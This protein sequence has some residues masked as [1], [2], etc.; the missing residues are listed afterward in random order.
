MRATPGTRPR[1]ASSSPI[2]SA[3]WDDLAAQ[4]ALPEELY[5]VE[6]G[7]GNGNQAKVFLDQFRHLDEAPAVATTAG[8]PLS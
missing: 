4:G 5:V 8:L 1:P 7:V 6:L 2:S 3:A